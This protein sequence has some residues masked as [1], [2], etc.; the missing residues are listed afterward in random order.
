M[1]AYLIFQRC[2]H[3][4]PKDKYGYTRLQRAYGKDEAAFL[5]GLGA[6]VNVKDPYGKT[7]LHR[8]VSENKKDIVEL[9]ITN[10]AVATQ[11]TMK[12]VR[13]CTRQFRTTVKKF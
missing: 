11:R 10:G 6:D 12:V 4:V 13:H 5:I 8:A 1:A 2:G 9:L 3:R 7:L